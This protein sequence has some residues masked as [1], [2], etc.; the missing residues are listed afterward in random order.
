[1]KTYDI[2]SMSDLYTLKAA[3]LK[4]A[5]MTALLLGNGH[6]ALKD[7]AGA[8]VL[9]VL[10]F[11]DGTAWVS[12]RFGVTKDWIAAHLEPLIA[13]MD[14]VELLGKRSSLND[15]G[16]Q[17]KEYAQALRAQLARQQGATS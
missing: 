5:Q 11:G 12:E 7:E 17:A 8:L 6:Y 16:K 1:M 3:D 15:I 4:V 14:S 2:V 13:C 10:A 9:P